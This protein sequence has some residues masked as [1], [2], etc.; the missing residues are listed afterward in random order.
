MKSSPN[1][2]RPREE[3][4]PVIG[5]GS[6]LSFRELNARLDAFLDKHGFVGGHP[7]QH[8]EHFWRRGRAH[9]G[10]KNAGQALKVPRAF[11]DIWEQL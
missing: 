2:F 10:Q 8:P 5:R 6:G 9:R 4:R 11:R 1:Y 7:K 3:Y